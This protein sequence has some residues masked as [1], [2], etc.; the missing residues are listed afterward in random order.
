[1]PTYIALN[2]GLKLSS[3]RWSFQEPTKVGVFLG[4]TL[5]CKKN[6]VF[7][8]EAKLEC[9]L[10]KVSNLISRRKTMFREL[11]RVYGSIISAILATGKQ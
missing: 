11:S 1:M 8:P 9:I 5:N 3:N 6:R 2:C 4:L 10:K 7:I